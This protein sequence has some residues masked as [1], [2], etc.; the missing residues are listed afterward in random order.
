M[1]RSAGRTDRVR[2]D[3]P[4]TERRHL[5]G[6]TGVRD[7]GDW[8]LNGPSGSTRECT[9]PPMTWSSPDLGGAVTRG[10]TAFF[11]P[12]DRRGLVD[13]HWWTLNSRRPRRGHPARRAGAGQCD[14]RCEAAGCVAHVH[15]ENRIRQ[16]A[17][18]W[19]RR[20]SDRPEVAYAGSGHLRPAAATRQ[21]IQ[22]RWWSCIRGGAVR[23]LV[24]RPRGS[25]TGCRHMN[26]QRQ[27]SMCNYRA[28]GGLRGGRPGHAGDGGWATPGTRRSSTLPPT[29]AGTASP[30]LRE[31]Q[32]RRWPATVRVRRPA[33]GPFRCRRC[34]R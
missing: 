32:I 24:R 26:H 23:G 27:V 12:T 16:A 28:T 5:D 7:G 14:L 11:V 29:T 9:R 20:S 19:R 8:V 34:V 13:F 10:H 17:S 15:A 21:A 25:W 4:D 33:Q 31:V 22:C 2:A 18:G 3:R 6:D 1:S 30:R